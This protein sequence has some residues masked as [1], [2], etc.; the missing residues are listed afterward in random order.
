LN[1]DGVHR[2]DGPYICAEAVILAPGGKTNALCRVSCRANSGD[3]EEEHICRKLAGGLRI[4]VWQVLSEREKG[5]QKGTVELTHLREAI[6]TQRFVTFYPG[7]HREMNDRVKTLLAEAG[8]QVS[9][10]S[11]DNPE[12][13][14]SIV[15]GGISYAGMDQISD[16]IQYGMR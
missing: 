14:V 16:Y 6:D 1:L 4:K 13:V 5:L 12:F 15:A 3:L 7:P 10:V 11:P 2:E 8:I 9:E